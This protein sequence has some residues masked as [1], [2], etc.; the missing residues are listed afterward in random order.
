MN[1]KALLLDFGGPVLKTPFEL[2]D[3]VETRLRLPEGRLD[4]AG[5]FDPARD[6]LWCDMQA[7]DITEREYWKRR[8]AEAA[9][10]VGRPLTLKGFFSVLYDRDE[11][12]LVRREALDVLDLAR[13]AG[14]PVGILTNDLAVYSTPAWIAR[15]T[16]LKLFDAIVDCSTMRFLK[17]DPRAYAAG[18]EALG[19]DPTATVFVDDQPRNIRGAVEAGLVAI[20]LDPQQPAVAFESARAALGL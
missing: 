8:V 16:V 19:A 2:L 18:V 7:G 1:D 12:D 6:P 5:P 14:V 3:W 13:A 15:M 10:A 4:W 9:K 20:H 17:P 11:Q